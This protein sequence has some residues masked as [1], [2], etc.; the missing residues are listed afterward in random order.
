M[1][2]RRQ[3]AAGAG[4]CADGGGVRRNERDEWADP[5][6][7]PGVGRLAR[8]DCPLGSRFNVWTETCATIWFGAGTPDLDS[9]KEACERYLDGVWLSPP[10]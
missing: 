5:A 9:R 2:E 10:Q 3:S 4:E 7:L 1:G 8:K 6:R